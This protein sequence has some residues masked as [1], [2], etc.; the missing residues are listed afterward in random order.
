MARAVAERHGGRLTLAP[1]DG[2]LGLRA[3]LCWEPA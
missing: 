2:G 3:S 1:G